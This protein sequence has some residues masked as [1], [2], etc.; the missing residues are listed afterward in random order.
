MNNVEADGQLAALLKEYADMF[1]STTGSIKGH[2][3]HL[4]FK[5][6]ALFKLNKAW[7]V[8]FA[9]RPLVEEE[10]ERLVQVGVL[11]PVDIAEF[12]TTPLVVVPKPNGRVRFCGDFKVSVNP[13]LNS[14]QYPMPTC[15]EVFQTLA[16]GKHF[17]KLDLADAYLQ[18]EMDEES[19]RYVVFT[20]HK[21][22]YRVNRFA[23]GLAC[24]PA[25]FQAVI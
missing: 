5:P 14:Q 1:E 2:V 12:T 24:A 8:P 15:Y 13:H 20:T 25:I 9:Y 23:F 4:Y 22:L 11:T 6:G 18:L 19:R 21:G 3:A 7:P 16:G 10:L 17:T